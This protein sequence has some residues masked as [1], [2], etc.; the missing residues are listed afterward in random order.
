[1]RMAIIITVIR[2]FSR[3]LPRMKLHSKCVENSLPF[4]LH[5]V[6]PWL[7]PVVLASSDE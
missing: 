6:F 3:R 1:L 7:H 2:A 4:C 5:G